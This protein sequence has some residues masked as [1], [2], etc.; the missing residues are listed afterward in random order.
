MSPNT[1][2]KLIFGP[3]PTETLDPVL[4][5]LNE[6]VIIA[7]F[8]NT[9]D[10]L[11]V[12]AK[13]NKTL[14]NNDTPVDSGGLNFEVGQLLVLKEENSDEIW[15]VT[16][17]TVSEVTALK[18][19]AAAVTTPEPSTFIFLGLGLVGLIGFRRWKNRK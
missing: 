18:T 11:Q 15:N 9:S 16:I 2:L 13:E 1:T 12:F 19:T 17:T 10:Q 8:K 7:T 6:K 5:W 3:P 14:L 4:D